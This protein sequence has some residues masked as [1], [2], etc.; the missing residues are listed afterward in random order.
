MLTAWASFRLAHADTDETV[1]AEDEL[2]YA[3]TRR[4]FS[5]WGAPEGKLILE[6]IERASRELAEVIVDRVF[7]EVRWQ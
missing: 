4:S 5:A 7:L 2:M 3:S 6:E 1:H